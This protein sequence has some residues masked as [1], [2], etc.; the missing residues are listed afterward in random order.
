VAIENDDTA[1]KIEHIE[2]ENLRIEPAEDTEE[3]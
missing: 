1:I 2:P 3:L